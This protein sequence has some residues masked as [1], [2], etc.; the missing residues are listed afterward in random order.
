MFCVCAF[1]GYP[2]III[3]AG[4]VSKVSVSNIQH[5]TSH[6]WA[7]YLKPALR[8]VCT[9][10]FIFINLRI[11]CVRCFLLRGS[12]FI[13]RAI[14]EPF[15]G[16]YL[17]SILPPLAT[18]TVC[19]ELPARAIPTLALHLLHLNGVR[20]NDEVD[21]VVTFACCRILFV[22]FVSKSDVTL[23]NTSKSTTSRLG[24]KLRSIS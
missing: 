17:N 20:Y 22:L 21:I 23:I 13:I 10:V 2:A 24:P 12:D 5:P 14:Y 7:D 3:F 16:R 11:F 9:S 19:R 8:R 18:P 4:T 1:D 15:A 6:N